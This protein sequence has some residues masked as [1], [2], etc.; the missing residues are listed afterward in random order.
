MKI[1]M[2]LTDVLGNTG[3]KTELWLEEFAAPYFVFRDAGVALTLASP[4]GHQP[5]IDLKSDLPENHTLPMARFKHDAAAQEALAR[6]VKLADVKTEDYDAV[7]YPGGHGAIWDLA[8]SP[9]S[10]A[11]L[12]SFGRLLV[13]ERLLRLGA[14]FEKVSNLEP[15][16]ITAGRVITGENPASPTSAAEALLRTMEQRSAA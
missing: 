3:R 13:E 8:E 10:I 12:E 1:L 5:R 6:A 11:L 14:I 4:D 7:F 15:F 2:V 9:D 16:A